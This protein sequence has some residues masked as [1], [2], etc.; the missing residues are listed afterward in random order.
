VLLR[1]GRAEQALAALDGIAEATDDEALRYLAYLFEGQA[2]EALGQDAEARS[3]YGRAL[4][5]KPRAQSASMALAA[6][7]FQDGQRGV[8]DQ[9]VAE[10]LSRTTQPDDPWWMYWP[11]DFRRAPELM[12]AMREALS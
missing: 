8:A 5:V 9:I 4:G 3:A 6:L 2:H 1:R 7:L 12:R 10:L 11:A